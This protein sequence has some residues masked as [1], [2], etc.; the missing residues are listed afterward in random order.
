MA[1]TS[2]GRG[3]SGLS[4]RLD[5][6]GKSSSFVMIGLEGVVLAAIALYMI[7]TPDSARD[8]I[9]LIAGLVFV[10]AGCYQL[11]RAFSLYHENTHRPVVPIRFI[12]GSAMLFGGILI[13]LEKL[14][15]HFNID[16][17][18]IVLASTLIAAGLFGL[19]AGM[20]V[21]RDGDM[22]LGN[23]V[24]SVILLVLAAF[25][26]SE[27]RSGND[28]T[29]TVGVIVLLLGLTMI[30]YAYLLSQR[31]PAQPAAVD[32]PRMSVPGA[33]TSE[34]VESE[35][36]AYDAPVSAPPPGDGYEPETAPAPEPEPAPTPDGEP[37]R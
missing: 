32:Q 12:G 27:V 34:P 31:S 21:R 5:S 23:M 13:V 16:A 33:E 11:L 19:I 25:N 8:N 24:A 3:F 29:R 30:G 14:T 6:N 26:I 35:P 2:A 20:L 9:R 28:Q 17:A 22:K 36:E 15:G 37:P 1:E 4:S 10:I 18:R 7:A